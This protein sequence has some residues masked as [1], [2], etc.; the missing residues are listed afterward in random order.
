MKKSGQR[1]TKT[2][3]SDV[4]IKIPEAPNDYRGQRLREERRFQL[5]H[6]M[7]SALFQKLPLSHG[8]PNGLGTSGHPGSME[9]LFAKESPLINGLIY[10]LD[11]SA[12]L[13]AC[14]NPNKDDQEQVCVIVHLCE[15]H[16]FDYYADFIWRIY[17]WPDGR[18]N[19]CGNKSD[20]DLWSEYTW[21]NGVA[22]MIEMLTLEAE[23]ARENANKRL[24][25]LNAFRTAFIPLNQVF[26]TW[27]FCTKKQ[28]SG[29]FFE[30][31]FTPSPANISPSV[32]F[33]SFSNLL[34]YPLRRS[35]RRGYH[36]LGPCRA[37]SR[38]I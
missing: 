33:Y 27:F 3:T 4:K 18:V 34:A 25:A 12:N 6:E 1:K 13:N 2:A 19:C 38:R 8:L 10:G 30:S 22:K 20:E 15:V 35:H 7:L 29:C 21:E 32:T 28:P 26:V 14:S 24:E 11:L 36:R 17:F 9:M 23:T 37:P 31:S 5:L 16:Q